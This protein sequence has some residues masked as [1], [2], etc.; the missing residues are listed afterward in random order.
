MDFSKVAPPIFDGEDYD[1]WAVRM[2]AF[3]DALDLSETVEDDYDVSSLPKYPTAEQMKT[4]KERKTKRAKAKTCL[5]A[6][7]SQTVFIKIMTL[8]TPKEIWDYLKEEYKGDERIRS[9]QV[10][11]LLREFEL[12]RIKEDEIIKTYADKLLG[13]ANKVRLLGT[14]FS[15]S[16]IVE[17]LLVTV[18]E[19]YEASIAALENTKDLSKIT[20]PE[21]LHALQTQEQRRLMR[22]ERTIDGIC[23]AKGFGKKYQHKPCPHCK[24]DNHSPN[25]CWWRPDA[26][27]EKCG[28]L[29]H[30][31]KV[32]TSQQQQG[33]VNIAHKQYEEDQELLLA[34]SGFTTN[35]PSKEWLVD[36]GCTNHM[37]YDR[38]L[39]KE[40]NKTSISKVRIGNGEQI[41]VEGIGTISIKT[42]AGMKQISNVLYVPEINQNLLSVAQLLEKNYKVIFEHKS[43][44]IKDQNNKEVITSQIKGKRFV[45]D[46]MKNDHIIEEKKEL[47]FKEDREDSDI[48]KKFQVK[49]ENK[50]ACEK[51]P[52]SHN[53]CNV[54][55]MKSTMHKDAKACD[56]KKNQNKKNNFSR[57]SDWIRTKEIQSRRMARIRGRDGRI[58][59]SEDLGHE[60]FL[61]RQAEE[62]QEEELVP[63]VPPVVQPVVW[64]GGPIDTSLLT[65]YH[66]HVA[67]HVWFGEECHGPRIEL[68]IASLGGKLVE[69]VP[70]QHPPIVE[71]W[72]TASGLSPLE[73][74]SLNKV[75]PNLISAFVER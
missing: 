44:V 24:K 74:T 3:L 26:K 18:P 59:R 53:K 67:R 69:W 47:K 21:V 62:Q 27:C 48:L 28:K 14:Q 61:W 71:G 64:P 31:M 22:E 57:S 38:D 10:M 46:L 60:E 16:R 9:M 55:T 15:D 7:V 50:Y 19:R 58:R 66:E 32:C 8:K 63:K 34:I 30:M 42:H 12:Q 35:K 51:S 33:D 5:F 2:E 40:L 25:N 75:G 6:S 73:R 13:I 37:T 70:D 1:L 29:G 52:K 17:K 4:H 23:L 36:S 11:N 56:K 49:E 41:A 43:C 72:M 65:R 54:S 68:K 39:F 45:L 20:L